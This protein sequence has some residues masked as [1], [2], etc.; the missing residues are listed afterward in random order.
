MD[1]DSL[2]DTG[3]RYL[4]PVM[5][6]VLDFAVRSSVC[7]SVPFGP[8]NSVIERSSLEEIFSSSSV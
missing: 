8:I 4:A 1:I 6:L 5:C 3:S 7:L 2:P